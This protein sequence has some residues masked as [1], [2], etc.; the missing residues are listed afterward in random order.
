MVLLRYWHQRRH[1]LES[2]YEGTEAVPSFAA[3]FTDVRRAEVVAVSKTSV[4]GV[5][6][7]VA[8]WSAYARH[9]SL[10]PE[11]AADPLPA[12]R[13]EL[14]AALGGAGDAAEVVDMERPFFAVMAR[15][16]AGN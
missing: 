10:H 4:E 5:A 16:K 14:A 15:R 2:G 8:S 6:G 7:Y 9:R 3:N 13:R 11:E 1:F 12:F